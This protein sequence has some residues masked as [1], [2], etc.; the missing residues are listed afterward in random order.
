M[1]N[2]KFLLLLF[3]C[4]VATKSLL[5][6]LV[7]APSMFSDEYEYAKI[8]QN[9]WEHQTFK[10]HGKP[11]NVPPGYPTM[12]SPAYWFDDMRDVYLAIK[13]INALLSSLIIFPA[14]LLAKDL[15]SR[16]LALTSTTLVSILPA[17]FSNTPYI[18]AENL[19]LVLMLTTAYFMYKSITTKGKTRLASLIGFSAFTLFAYLT[20]VLGIVIL[21]AAG[22]AYIFVTTDILAKIIKRNTDSSFLFK[23]ILLIGFLSALTFSI[24]MIIA[25]K[26]FPLYQYINYFFPKEQNTVTQILI[27]SIFWMSIY[28]GYLIIASGFV[29]ILR[30]FSIKSANHKKRMYMLVLGALA[31]A[32][33]AVAMKHNINVSFLNTTIFSLLSGRPM[34]RY[35]DYLLPLIIIGGFAVVNTK[36]NKKAAYLLSALAIISA[37][38]LS[39]Y[40][41]I[42]INNGSLSILGT[43]KLTFEKL[44]GPAELLSTGYFLVSIITAMIAITIITISL[45]CKKATSIAVMLAILF[46]TTNTI[47]YSIAIYNAKTYW[48]N[49]EQMQLGLWINDNKEFRGKTILIDEK[50]EG[51]LLKRNQ[52]AL[53]EAGSATILGFWIKN[54]MKIGSTQD[55]KDIDYVITK[56]KLDLP[57][58]KRTTNEIYLYKAPDGSEK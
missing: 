41:L 42:P 20:K 3:L 19:F 46:I 57:L 54:H 58:I 6:A 4:L 30:I 33:I 53:H 48:Y 23:N 56:D 10:I 13:I 18:M 12:I 22:L 28:S 5:A 16:R 11:I 1:K 52:R 49:G 55:L 25:L 35:L 37:I 39:T 45:K 14:Y 9:F 21:F 36:I 8:A 47:N 27:S 29:P 17:S 31:I 50:Y 7:P 43:A 32:G 15:M 2:W 38:F 24:V 40:D 44:I 26:F 34:G 51:K